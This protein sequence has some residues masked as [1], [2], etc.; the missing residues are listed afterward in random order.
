M[1]SL[2]LL[3]KF[4]MKLY[5]VPILCSR[6]E[7]SERYVPHGVTFNNASL[8]PIVYLCTSFVFSRKKQ[9]LFPSSISS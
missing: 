4:N 2:P 6:S 7:G 9:Q 5:T 1:R 8:F 3:L